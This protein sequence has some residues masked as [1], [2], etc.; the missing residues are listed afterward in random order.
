MP[1]PGAKG[2]T[3]REGMGSDGKGCTPWVRCNS[4]LMRGK[5]SAVGRL[6]HCP[7]SFSIPAASI[8]EALVIPGLF[9]FEEM[10]SLTEVPELGD[11]FVRG[12]KVESD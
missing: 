12:P 8:E 3:Q 1:S 7:E 2:C 9:H 5:P 11:L 4:G 6:A 10:R